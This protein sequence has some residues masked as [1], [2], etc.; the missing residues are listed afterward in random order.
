[1]QGASAEDHALAHLEHHRHGIEFLYLFLTYAGPM[2]DKARRGFRIVVH[3]LFDERVD[4]LLDAPTLCFDAMMEMSFIYLTLYNHTGNGIVGFHYDPLFL[5][6]APRASAQEA[7]QKKT[8]QVGKNNE[9]VETDETKLVK[10]NIT[11]IREDQPTYL[12]LQVDATT[13]ANNTYACNKLALASQEETHNE[14][15]PQVLDHF[16]VRAMSAQDAPDEICANLDMTLHTLS[17]L[18]REYPTLPADPQYPTHHL[19]YSKN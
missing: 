14:E 18:I 11:R 9:Q 5:H 7:K 6:R 15:D 2:K 19:T 3:S 1:M 10:I 4:P 16:V 8:W 12:Q 17:L 13:S